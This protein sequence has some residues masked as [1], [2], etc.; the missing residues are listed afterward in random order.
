MN[1]L[2]RTDRDDIDA[3]MPQRLLEVVVH[4]DTLSPAP[5]ARALALPASADS[6]H[7]RVRIAEKAATMLPEPIGSM[8]RTPIFPFFIGTRADSSQCEGLNIS[9]METG[10]PRFTRDDLR[11][12]RLHRPPVL[13]LGIPR[14]SA[15]PAIRVLSANTLPICSRSS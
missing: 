8:T 6:D 4:G 15:V 3:V 14:A 10:S 11:D 13:A 2:R 5:S 9:T 1:M 12:A 7:L